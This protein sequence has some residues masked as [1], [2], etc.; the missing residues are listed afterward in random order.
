[1]TT[2]AILKALDEMHDCASRWI[3]ESD[4]EEPMPPRE[5]E[6]AIVAIKIALA[7]H[8]TVVACGRRMGKIP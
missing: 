6:E 8:H 3:A 2:E 1:M 4:R 7:T 5:W